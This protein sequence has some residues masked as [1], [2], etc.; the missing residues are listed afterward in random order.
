MSRIQPISIGFSFFRFDV[1]VGL[2]PQVLVLL[3]VG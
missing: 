2:V 1:S 3:T